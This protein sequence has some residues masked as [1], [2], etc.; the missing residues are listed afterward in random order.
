M[1]QIDPR[2]RARGPAKRAVEQAR[3]FEAAKLDLRH[4]VEDIGI[5][6][7][8]GGHHGEGDERQT[9]NDC[10][11]RHCRRRQRTGHVHQCAGDVDPTA[12]H[13]ADD[14][15]D[16]KPDQKRGDADQEIRLRHHA[17]VFKRAVHGKRKDRDQNAA[18][19][20]LGAC[21]NGEAP[22]AGRRGVA[23]PLGYSSLV[24]RSGSGCSLVSSAEIEVRCI[25]GSDVRS[26]LAR[27]SACV[28]VA[29]STRTP[30]RCGARRFFLP[31]SPNCP[32]AP[33]VMAMPGEGGEIRRRRSN[34]PGNSQVP[35]PA[36]LKH[37]G[38]RPGNGPTVG[39]SPFTGEALRFHA[40]RGHAAP[41]APCEGA[42]P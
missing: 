21:Q 11:G 34:R 41:A 28:T 23:Q 22:N 15:G 35:G 37:S 20:G 25:P 27:R 1:K 14:K 7:D 30:R 16:E 36:W 39:E 5:E 29:F 42:C 4:V 38:K 31:D 10:R 18:R 6:A 17:R 2:G 24:H 19:N 40:R 8:E 3:G 12:G 32:N 33:A 26:F 13:E 9:C